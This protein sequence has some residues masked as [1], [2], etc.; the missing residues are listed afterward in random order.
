[1]RHKSISNTSKVFCLKSVVFLIVLLS[2]SAATIKKENTNLALESAPKFETH[3]RQIQLKNVKPH[4]ATIMKTDINNYKLK[5]EKEGVEN[6]ELT[7]TVKEKIL[8]HHDGENKKAED[9]E[10]TNGLIYDTFSLYLSGFGDKTF[11]ISTIACV[12]YN[13]WISA[14][15]TFIGLLIM[16]IL[17]LYLGLEISQYV[18]LYVIDVASSI[19]FILMGLHM[20]YEA[21]YEEEAP[22]KQNS[23][24]KKKE[25]DNGIDKNVKQVNKYLNEENNT[26]NE[27][28]NEINREEEIRKLNEEIV[29]EIAGTTDEEE[30]YRNSNDVLQNDFE[31]RFNYNKALMS[32]E[33]SI[34]FYSLGKKNQEIMNNVVNESKFNSFK[35]L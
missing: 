7:T 3:Q 35:N 30:A 17:S 26:E 25:I 29:F 2:F 23:N 32:R 16:G 28:E 19:L 22:E 15:G 8:K 4:D 20:I 11:F 34:D 18:P 12:N 6:S 9:K 33:A 27:N 24:E 1:M 31:S 10:T 5:T 14:L 13:K 21:Y